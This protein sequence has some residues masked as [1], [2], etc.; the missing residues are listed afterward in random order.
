[1]IKPNESE[2]H[3][4]TVGRLTAV[5]AMIIAV[6]AAKPFLGGF[7]SAFQTVQEYTGFIAPGVVAVFLLGMFYQKTN[8]AGAFTALI[9]SVLLSI[10]FKLVF[11]GFEFVNRIWVVFLL[12]ILCGIGVSHVE[13]IDREDKREML[14]FG[15]IA[16]ALFAYA[17]T[18]YT[19]FNRLLATIF[20]S[21]IIGTLISN[22]TKKV[23]ESQLVRL[24]DVNFATNKTFN[25]WTI[26]ITVILIALYAKFW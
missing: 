24:N 11:P 2:T 4:V 19:G 16:F 12:C 15:V 8:S 25:I 5:I 9:L 6:I 23:T 1:M 10:L 7:E 26:V 22:S 13:N 3:Y 18:E 17:F 20:V 14:F 21:I